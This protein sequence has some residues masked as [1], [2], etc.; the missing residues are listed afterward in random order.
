MPKRIA[1]FVSP[2]GFGHAA[3]ASA[4]M[5]SVYDM[6]PL[7]HFEIFTTIPVWFFEESLKSPYGYHSLLTDVGL[8]QETPLCADLA[9]T[10]ERLNRFIPFEKSQ[11]WKLA[12]KID[13]LNCELV[14]C[15]IAPMESRS[16]GKEGCPR[17][18]WRTSPGTGFIRN[19]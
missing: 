8:V 7:V 1:Y 16:P 15:D 17:C 11:M 6:D 5:N 3:R 19:I 4:V 12:M 18:W 2:H 13:R 9:G 14:I 10:V